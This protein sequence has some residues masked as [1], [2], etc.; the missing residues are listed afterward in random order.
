MENYMHT[1]YLKSSE[2]LNDDEI[3]SLSTLLKSNKGIENFRIS[4]DGI[5]LEYNSYLYSQIQIE[6]ILFKTGFRKKKDRR[7]GFVR[8]Q[9]KNLAKSNKKTYGSQKLDCCQLNE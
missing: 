8:R 7:L 1:I 2:I 9:I 5:Y 3:E 4:F 6:E